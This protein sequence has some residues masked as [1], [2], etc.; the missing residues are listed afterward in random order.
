M[1]QKCMLKLIGIPLWVK[2]PQ[3]TGRPCFEDVRVKA[4]PMPLSAQETADIESSMA[5]FLAKHR[6]PEHLRDKLDI[7][8]RIERQSVVIFEI[9]PFW[10]DESHK[11]EGPVAKATYVRKTDPKFE[12]QQA[13]LDW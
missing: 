11:I 4:L 5:D 2:A 10:R 8:W 1:Q 6:P 7:G 12:F 9:R 3:L 13:I